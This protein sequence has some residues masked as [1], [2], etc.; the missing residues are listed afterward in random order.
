[1]NA[2]NF[3]FSYIVF[4]LYIIHRAIYTYTLLHVT[5]LERT[6]LVTQYNGHLI[7]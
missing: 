4:V 6:I 3:P 2:A 5:A 1:M 7:I